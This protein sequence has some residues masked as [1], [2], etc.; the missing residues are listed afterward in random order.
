VIKISKQH[1]LVDEPDRAGLNSNLTTL[2]SMV[3]EMQKQGTVVC[4]VDIPLDPIIYNGKVEAGSRQI[5]EEYF[6]RSQYIWLG[7]TIKKVWTTVDGLHL[8]G[9]DAVAFERDI[10]H[11]LYM[12]LH[13]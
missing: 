8:T 6:P 5:I 2:K 12:I 9:G 4:F 3:D 13:K 1:W 7:P 11:Q 10:E